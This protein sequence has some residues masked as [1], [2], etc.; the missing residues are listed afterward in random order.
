[1]IADRN[2]DVDERI[3][4]INENILEMKIK[5]EKQQDFLIDLEERL[6]TLYESTEK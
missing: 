6:N 5:D 4:A 2:K 1:M 3:T